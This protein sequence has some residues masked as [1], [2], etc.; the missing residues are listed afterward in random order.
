MKLKSL[1][2]R[3]SGSTTPSYIKRLVRDAH[4]AATTS[5]MKQ[6]TLRRI[7]AAAAFRLAAL[8]TA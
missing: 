5:Y 6:K 2:S 7:E 4:E 8:E 3:I 1:R